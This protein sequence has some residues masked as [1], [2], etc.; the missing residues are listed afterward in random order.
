MIPLVICV[1]GCCTLSIV[2]GLGFLM[3]CKCRSAAVFVA[4][5]SASPKDE[6]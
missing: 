5:V 6:S 4:H 3:V 1:S 2:Q